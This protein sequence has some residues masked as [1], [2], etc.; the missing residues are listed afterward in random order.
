EGRESNIRVN[1][2][3]PGLTDTAANLAQMK[4]KETSKWA[5]KEH[6]AEVVRFLVSDAAAGITGQTIPVAG[7]GI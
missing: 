6:I 2:V 4:P 3:A 7:K 1:A 5:N